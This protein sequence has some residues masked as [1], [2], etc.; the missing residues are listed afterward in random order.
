MTTILIQSTPG[1]LA[2]IYEAA[3]LIKEKGPMRRLELFAAMDF[4]PER[5]RELKLREAF[6]TS[7]LREASSG[8]IELTE[9]SQQHFDRQKSAS[10]YVGEVTPPQYR[11]NWRTGTLSRQHIPNRRGT[12]A[13]VPE[14]SVRETV[15]I[16]TIGGRET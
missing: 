7:W 13:D 8:H 5:T 3:A 15:S 16:K 12:R 6:Q 1:K 10:T 14:W 4:G 9:Y 2:A 11:G